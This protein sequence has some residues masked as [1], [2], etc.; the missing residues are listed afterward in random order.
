M[1][2][3]AT[4]IEPQVPESLRQQFDG[5]HTD[6]W[7]IANNLKLRN[8]P[9]ERLPL[10]PDSL[11]V[12][13]NRA[14][15]YARLAEVDCR[16]D[17]CFVA[18]EDSYHGFERGLPAIALDDQRQRALRLALIGG[19]GAAHRQALS[20][21]FPQ[22]ELMIVPRDSIAMRGYPRALTASSGF[23]VLQI[24]HAIESAR[25]AAGLPRRPV[26]LIGFTGFGRSAWRGHDWWAEQQWLQA[27]PV[28]LHAGDARDSFHR[29]RA[30]RWWLHHRL[31]LSKGRK[32]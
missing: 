8:F 30:C 4:T 15:F 10:S 20:D 22:A 17:F 18:V 29:L 9:L 24:H 26:H 14:R 31:A 23:V 13:F 5:P 12:Q 16:K 1:L 6:V 25:A 21:A 32:S 11:L 2:P 3:P 19:D 7:L 27:A 28:T